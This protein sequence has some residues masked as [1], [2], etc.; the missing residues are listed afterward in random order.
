MKPVQ[1]GVLSTAKIGLQQVIPALAAS[2]LCALAAIASRD[3]DRAARAA[4]DLGFARH[5][6]SY[7]AL[8]DDP[9]VE[10][11]YNPLPNHLHV[12]WSIKAAEKGKHVL[13]EKPLSLTVA[14]AEELLAARDRTG[15]VVAE[16]F[17]V[18]H[19]P[20]WHRVRDLVGQG[21]IGDLRAV[22]A[23][24]SYHN[25][26]AANI[27]NRMETGGGALYDIGVY[28]VVVARYLF[29][30]EPRRVVALV[31]RDPDFGTDRLSSAILD[32]DGGQAQFTCS[33]RL[34]PFQRVQVL[35]TAGRIEVE[36]PFNAP[37][38][39][40][41]RLFLD[42][43][44]ARDGSSVTEEWID[45]CDQY[46]LQGEAF[47]RAVRGAAPLAHPLED[48]VAN[49]RVVEALFASAATGTWREP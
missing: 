26:D 11:V 48:A 36:I 43:T 20:Q 25:T 29:G 1:W 5:Y 21:V 45:P 35:G 19:H 28:P 10:A 13:C 40:A 44:G 33:T 24:F 27:R 8:L 12:P 2:P 31:E 23:A 30:A 49:M 18:R 16:A 32:F 22:Q 14:E 47:A 6:D 34:V 37:A 42:P 46:T 41:T 9:E 3:G 17:M 15:V 7:E 4:A 38:G 39:G